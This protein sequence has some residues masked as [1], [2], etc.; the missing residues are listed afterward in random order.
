[1]IPTR[2]ETNW[3]KI[4]PEIKRCWPKLSD[5]DLASVSYQASTLVEIVRRG[6]H[7]GRSGITIEAGVLDWLNRTMDGI[8]KEVE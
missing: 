5:S 3:N 2:L 7:L 1:M 8:E 6:Y 4:E